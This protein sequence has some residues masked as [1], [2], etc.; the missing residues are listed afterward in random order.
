MKRSLQFAT[1]LIVMFALVF[2]PLGAASASGSSTDVFFGPDG[3]T[4]IKVKDDFSNL[5]DRDPFAPSSV[6]EPYFVADSVCSAS[7]PLPGLFYGYQNDCG[8]VA[9]IVSK[10][11]NSGMP[12]AHF[13]IKNDPG[14]DPENPNYIL[15]DLQDGPSGMNYHGYGGGWQR[16]RPTVGNPVRISFDMRLPGCN[17]DGTGCGTG[18]QG[19]VMWNAPIGVGPNGIADDYKHFGFTFASADN[20]RGLVGLTCG[21]I[22]NLAPGDTHQAAGDPSVWRNYVMVWAQNEDGSQ[23]VTYKIDGEVCGVTNFTATEAAELGALGSEIW[24]DNYLFIFYPDGSY[25]VTFVNPPVGSPRTM[26]VANY[27]IKYKDIND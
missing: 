25:E 17:E 9:K 19:F 2:A 8:D 1:L 7:L 11:T 4:V 14:F 13:K 27:K 20:D 26:D 23:S 5:V 15:A 22:W 10:T 16:W 21:V 3:T 12:Y 24:L 18:T 6:T